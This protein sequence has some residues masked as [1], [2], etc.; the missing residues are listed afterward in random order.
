MDTVGKVDL[1]DKDYL[2]VLMKNHVDVPD[3][4]FIDNSLLLLYTVNPEL[5]DTQ[6]W[7]DSAIRC[8]KK[9]VQTIKNKLC[10]YID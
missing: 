6:T 5:F 2:S 9:S 8:N 4:A 1:T 3:F 10:K 7:K